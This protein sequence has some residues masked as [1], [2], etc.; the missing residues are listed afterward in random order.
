MIT[1]YM[2]E[3]VLI[4][5]SFPPT[6]TERKV[7]Q[8]STLRCVEDLEQENTLRCV[9]EQ[10]N[11]ICCESG[12]SNPRSMVHISVIL[13][14]V[15]VWLLAIGV[16]V[17]FFHYRHPPQYEAVVERSPAILYHG[18]ALLCCSQLHV[19]YESILSLPGERCCVVWT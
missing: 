15:L 3:P 14:I 4:A 12:P 16:V 18:H 6:P 1:C 5:L 13:G 19:L 8:G 10:D 7:K 2:M 11:A 17:Y 9:E